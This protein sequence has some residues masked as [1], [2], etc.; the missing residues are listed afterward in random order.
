MVTKQTFTYI[1]RELIVSI[2]LKGIGAHARTSLQFRNLDI[3]EDC[4]VH[5]KGSD[6]LSTVNMGRV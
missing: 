6:N 5:Q 2:E 1:T 4:S 3:T